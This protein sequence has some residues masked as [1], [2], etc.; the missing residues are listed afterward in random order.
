MPDWEPMHLF[1]R[2]LPRLRDRG[3]TDA[4]IRTIFVDNPRRYFDGHE[5]PVKVSPKSR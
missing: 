5:G 2:I 4:D 3:V 1:K